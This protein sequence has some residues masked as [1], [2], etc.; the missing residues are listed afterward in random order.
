MAR[1]VFKPRKDSKKPKSAIATKKARPIRKSVSAKTHPTK[2][3]KKAE[4]KIIGLKKA[5]QKKPQT[6]AQKKAP[7]KEMPSSDQKGDIQ[8]NPRLNE[9]C[10]FCNNKLI[11]EAVQKEDLGLLKK[12]LADKD[13]ITNP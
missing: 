1:T 5:D 13:N 4:K 7:A 2:I 6:T 10:M 9:C 12:L 8:H 3:T 11:A